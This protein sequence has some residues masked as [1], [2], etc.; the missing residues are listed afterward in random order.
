[1][2]ILPRVYSAYA[3]RNPRAKAL[4]LH[5]K[6]LGSLGKLW[7]SA[8]SRPREVGDIS[9]SPRASALGAQGLAS[10]DRTFSRHES[11]LRE[12]RRLGPASPHSK[13]LPSR[14]TVRAVRSRSAF[15]D[16]RRR[17]SVWSSLRFQNQLRH[18][19]DEER[20]DVV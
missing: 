20:R 19:R 17:L 13:I 3:D 2:R 6:A 14:R 12:R 18:F 15:T 4:G 11:D 9:W 10:G 7:T 16:A 1:M 5:R 8:E